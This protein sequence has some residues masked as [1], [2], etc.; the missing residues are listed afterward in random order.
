MIYM[1]FDWHIEKDLM[2]GEYVT[3]S[4]PLLT[5]NRTLRTCGGTETFTSATIFVKCGLELA[6]DRRN[7]TS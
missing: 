1:K 4:M 2:E 7:A 3:G 5:P 6:Q